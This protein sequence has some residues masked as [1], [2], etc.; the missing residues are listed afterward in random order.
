VRQRIVDALT[1]DLTL[2]L[3]SLGLAFLLWSL[4]KTGNQMGIDGVPIEVVNRDA[5]WVLSG[6]PD[7][8]T[9]RVVFSGP[10][11]ELFRMMA[12]EPPNVLVPID[13]VTDTSEFVAL[14][15]N[16]VALGQ[17]MNNTR[18]EEIRPSAVRLHFDRVT[19]REVPVSIV[20]IGQPTAGFELAGP[21]RLE[22]SSVRVSGGSRL[23][24]PIDTL[25]LRPLD[26]SRYGATDTVIVPV[27]VD[28]VG[29][30]LVVVPNEIR[31]IVPI[32]PIASDSSTVEPVTGGGEG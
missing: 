13:E 25:R 26:L 2:K 12:A 14:R 11:R 27:P 16:W 7:P 15:P 10:V 1:N 20:L 6:Q 24:A 32:R 5:G 9:V 21:I 17:G 4:V 31:V 22:P 23:L 30:D 29:G 19:S 8:P 18:V 3:I 28:A